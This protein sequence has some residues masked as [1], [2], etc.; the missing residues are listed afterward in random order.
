MSDDPQLQVFLGVV[1]FRALVPKP[2]PA[3]T[4]VSLEGGSFLFR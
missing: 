2:V 1:V 4:M 3:L